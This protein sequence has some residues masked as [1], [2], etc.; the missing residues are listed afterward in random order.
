MATQSQIAKP[1]TGTPFV[2]EIADM[3]FATKTIEKVGKGEGTW[4]DLAMLGITAASFTVLPAKL[5]TLSG[6]ALWQVIKA[7][8]KVVNSEVASVA[9][10]RAAAKTLE[11]ALAVK[12]KSPFVRPREE[13]GSLG[14][15]TPRPLP[16][17][18]G[19]Y[20]DEGLDTVKKEESGPGF[21]AKM[22]SE[23]VDSYLEKRDEL[24]SLKKDRLTITGRLKKGKKVDD[25]EN[26]DKKS[27][28]S[29]IDDRINELETYLEKNAKN[30]G[31]TYNRLYPEN[32]DIAEIA[33]SGLAS[34]RA[35]KMTAKERAKA[36]STQGRYEKRMSLS[37]AEAR[38]RVNKMDEELTK[39]ENKEAFDFAEDEAGTKIGGRSFEGKVKEQL[40]EGVAQQQTLKAKDDG[41]ILAKSDRPVLAEMSELQDDLKNAMDN[42]SKAKNP[43]EKKLYTE[44]VRQA[45]KA[46]KERTKFSNLG[47]SAKP[48]TSTQEQKELGDRLFVL[49]DRRVP[50]Y[51]GYDTEKSSV[52]D[53]N[54]YDR[55]RH[56]KN[57]LEKE[58]RDYLTS[59][60]KYQTQI[61]RR[62][63]LDDEASAAKYK[64]VIDDY[65]DELDKLEKLA[66]S[67]FKSLNDIVKNG[68]LNDVG[69]RQFMNNVAKNPIDKNNRKYLFELIEDLIDQ[70]K[71]PILKA[72][73]IKFVGSQKTV[74]R[75]AANKAAMQA[76][77][78]KEDI[79]IKARADKKAAAAR[80][81]QI[82]NN[83]E[84]TLHS[85]GAK[86]ADTAWAEAADRM[87][88]K[89]TAHS[90]EG[91]FGFSGKRPAL[92]TR[93]NLTQEQM[94]EQTKLVNQAGK[95]IGK[96]AGTTSAGGK[97]VHR[98]AY[99]VKDSEAVLAIAN[100]WTKIAD[101]TRVTVGGRG[102]PWA[103]EMGIILDKPVFVF[104]QGAGKWFKFNPKTNVWDEL[105]GLPPK[106]KNFAGIGTSSELKDSGR[107]AIDDYIEQFAKVKSTGSVVR[108]NKLTTAEQAD[109]VYIGRGAGDKGKFGNPFP[110]G[111]GVTVKESVN[112]YRTYLFEKIKSDPE[113][114]R[115]LYALKG[116]KL[117]CP[118]SEPND[119]CHG[120]VILRAI[121]YLE[122]NPELMKG[123]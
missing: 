23:F 3:L 84:I 83:S 102:T 119:A 51:R 4:G 15:M 55:I 10:K 99:Q 104:E 122:E 72:K 63:N 11:D 26:P 117:A 16:K 60:P 34:E 25:P 45:R 9:A 108:W 78:A 114:A 49:Q 97:L 14:G 54:I 92:E 57:I 17:Q 22:Q 8:N 36:K 6:K 41:S 112:K 106:F 24:K 35:V 109:A 40:D 89:T 86:G 42:L 28:T 53:Y 33:Y 29:E 61:V 101:G 73:M 50:R 13:V 90:F 121:K 80:R 12:S 118:G 30:F 94:R 38:T 107:K 65:K 43:A 74:G 70:V 75:G 85:G 69:I 27:I 52:S 100:G 96:S 71:D 87:G 105:D 21:D 113:Y 111:G 110:V 44:A 2:A 68:K 37:A 120:A 7:S 103:V 93:N 62:Y 77:L 66:D 19:D 56:I 47:T 95:V 18:V 20:I 123:K 67:S 48:L 115:D 88:I 31:E 98:N 58:G 64:K 5:L 81:E 59:D 46:I 39:Q 116:K 82:Q 79:A 76:R 1:E 32:G 91:H